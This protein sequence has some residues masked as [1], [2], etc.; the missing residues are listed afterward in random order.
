MTW[1]AG[2]EQITNARTL[3]G[4]YVTDPAVPWRLVFHTTYTDAS[5]NAWLI[6]YTDTADIELWYVP[7]S[8]GRWRIGR[9]GWGG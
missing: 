6:L 2:A 7:C 8:I 3:G 4:T 9:V 1:L 5:G